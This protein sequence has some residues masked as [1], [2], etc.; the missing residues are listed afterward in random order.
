MPLR[1]T[2]KKSFEA[3]ETV[4]NSL[5]VVQPVNG[6]DYPAIAKTLFYFLCF[7]KHALQLN[8]SIKLRIIN[9]QWKKVD[10]NNPFPD[11]DSA[12]LM[13]IAQD[14]SYRC[15]NQVANGRR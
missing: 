14:H 12:I 9:P 4:C 2:M 6:K 13:V 1:V 3:N 15:R 11:L 7:I 8:R 5:G 10:T